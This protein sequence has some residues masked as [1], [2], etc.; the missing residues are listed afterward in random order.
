MTNLKGNGNE[1]IAFVGPF[2]VGKTTALRVISDVGVINTEAKSTEVSRIQKAEGK[3][4]TTVGMD[5]GAW[6][7]DDGT[8]VELIGVP[9]QQRFSAVWNVLL[10]QCTAVVL[11]LSQESAD[12]E[13]DMEFWLRLLEEKGAIN[14]VAVAVTRATD[15]EE[16]V[17]LAY[18]R[19][20]V[21]K[22]HPCAPLLVADP[23]EKNH[24]VQAVMMALSTPYYDPQTAQL[25]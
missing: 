22:Y 2:G 15:F 3:T 24:V 23:R 8:R 19:P 4:T 20:L 25:S 12:L 5:Y 1:K 6:H 7:F 16:E 11:W 10:P 13:K 18:L 9:G 21:A 17:L 14:R